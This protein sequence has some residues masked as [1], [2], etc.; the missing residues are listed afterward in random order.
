M[1][2]DERLLFINHEIRVWLEI[3]GRLCADPAVK[4]GREASKQETKLGLAFQGEA[5]LLARFSGG[6]EVRSRSQRLPGNDV[7][8]RAHR[9]PARIEIRDG[10]PACLEGIVAGNGLA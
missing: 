7:D 3:T 8:I 2:N 6:V 5:F 9:E 4:F 1:T 10:K